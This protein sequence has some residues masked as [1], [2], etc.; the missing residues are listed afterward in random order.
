VNIMLCLGLPCMVAQVIDLKVCFIRWKTVCQLHHAQACIY[1]R[2][3]L[4]S[5]FSFFG[6]NSF[7]RVNQHRVHSRE[8]LPFKIQRLHS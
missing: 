3:Y 5:F 1:L 7:L 4:F 6:R 8:G 2:C